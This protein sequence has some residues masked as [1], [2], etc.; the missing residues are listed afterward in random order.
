MGYINVDI[1]IDDIV[2][3]LSRSEKRE[4][5]EELSEDL[6]YTYLETAEDDDRIAIT[7]NE[8]EL[9]SICDNIYKNRIALT[10]EDIALLVKFSKK[11][12]YE[13]VV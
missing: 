7:Y 5:M 3:G 13:K 8:Q 11:G 2:S 12:Y 10:N 9:K 4:L 1:R 6:G